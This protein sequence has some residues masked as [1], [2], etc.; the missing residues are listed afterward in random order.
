MHMEK[1]LALVDFFALPGCRDDS[2]RLY[3]ARV[4]SAAQLVIFAES[5]V[6]CLY[7]LLV[8]PF[9]AHNLLFTL[10]LPGPVLACSIVGLWLLRRRGQLQRSCHLSLAAI[11]VAIT[12]STA[13]TG[14]P[15]T[16][17]ISYVLT[18]MPLLALNVLGGR[19]AL[20]WLLISILLELALL[21]AAMVPGLLP[22]LPS[23]VVIAAHLIGW[24]IIAGSILA[25]TWGGILYSNRLSFE[26]K[27][28]RE[29]LRHLASHDRLTDL[30][31]RGLFEDRLQQA[32]ERAERCGDT[33]TLMY[34]DLVD[35]KGINDTYGHQTG[36][37]VLQIMGQRLKH[38]TRPTD[39]VARL[40]G[41]ELA[42]V[43]DG[44]APGDALQVAQ[45]LAERLA[46]PCQGTPVPLSIKASIGVAIFPQHAHNA[47]EIIA[48]ADEA[49]YHAKRNKL[50][51]L[52]WSDDIGKAV[53]E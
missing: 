40:G 39:T 46:K 23:E 13:F 1:M 45:I 7:V 34:I 12:L 9:P 4:L 43:L 20:R 53:V 51:C 22:T 18:V 8:A 29:R 52:V 33:V 26:L 47:R 6:A 42:V 5:L 3:R 11:A 35:F 2:D 48:R 10:I 41:D 17:G 28:E 38:N 30:A 16:S 32:L 15:L 25:F 31:N 19:A 49:M 36:D 21:T 24:F 14:G 37:L 44:V 50:P 27:D